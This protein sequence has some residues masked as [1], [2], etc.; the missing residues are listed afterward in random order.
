MTWVYLGCLLVP[1][2]WVAVALELVRREMFTVCILRRQ[3]GQWVRQK[4][5]SKRSKKIRHAI[6]TKGY[7][8][9]RDGKIEEGIQS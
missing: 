3:E 7:A 5:V 6:N 9:L 2:I 4:W 1:L 8:I